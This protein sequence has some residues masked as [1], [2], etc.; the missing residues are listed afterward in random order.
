MRGA[1]F[2]EGGPLSVSDLDGLRLGGGDV[3]FFKCHGLQGKK[4]I[5]VGT[6]L[7]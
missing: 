1:S 2:T 6:G 4:L 5:N 7:W 3:L